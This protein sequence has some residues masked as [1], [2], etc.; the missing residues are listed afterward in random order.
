M[1]RLLLA[2]LLLGA[3]ETP[4]AD[5]D[6]P[7]VVDDGP[8][9][10]G[11]EPSVRADLRLKRWRQVSLDLQGALSLTEDQICRETGLYDCADLHAV[12]LGGVSIA[13]GI[14]EPVDALSVTTGLAIERMV[15]QAC[16]NRLAL[17]RAAEAPVVFA[18]I[19]LDGDT[20]E[21]AQAE[22]QAATLYRRMLGRDP[23][24]EERDAL[25]GL[26]AGVVEDGGGNAEWALMSCFALG[27]STEALLY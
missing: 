18:E 7:E 15:L 9:W 10:T 23:E 16:W 12:P 17:D 27:T 20:L 22:A 6:P 2:V 25:V 19:P 13:N 8:D 21:V 5:S 11:A 24:P 3:C 14:F 1:S 26:H 4:P